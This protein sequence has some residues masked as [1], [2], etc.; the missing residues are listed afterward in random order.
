M[1]VN[2]ITVSMKNIK[3]LSFPIIGLFILLCQSCSNTSKAKVTVSCRELMSGCGDCEEC[4][5]LKV[6]GDTSQFSSLVGRTVQY[7]FK[8]AQTADKFDREMPS[9]KICCTYTFEG[10]MAISKESCKLV[11]DRYEIS[12]DSTCCNGSLP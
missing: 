8:D 12:V 5:I 9:C 6:V 7:S 2:I 4:R 1:K 10:E 11:V 3:S